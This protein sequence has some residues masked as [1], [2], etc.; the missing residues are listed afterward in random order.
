MAL[1]YEELESITTDY[2]VADNKQ[3]VDIYFNT[4][5][6]MDY[7]MKR[8]KGLWRRPP[9]GNLIR[10]PLMYDGAEGGFYSRSDSLSSDDRESLNAAYFQLISLN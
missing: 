10:V 3:A 6:L 8:Q 1:T 4:S 2:F 5:F 9:G 7:F